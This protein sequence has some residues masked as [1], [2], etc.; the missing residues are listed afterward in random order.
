MIAGKNFTIFLFV[1]LVSTFLPSHKSIDLY[2]ADFLE[3]WMD[4]K[5][6]YAYFHKKHTNWDKVKLVYLP[7]AKEAKNKQELIIIFEKALE[8]KCILTLFDIKATPNS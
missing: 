8:G 5:D 3:F 2:E 6:N 7:L 1:L 4:V